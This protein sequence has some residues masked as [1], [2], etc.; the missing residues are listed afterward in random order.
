M[1]AAGLY[2]SSKALHVIDKSGRYFV[3]DEESAQKLTEAVADCARAAARASKP[4]DT[5]IL[6]SALET[7]EQLDLSM[8]PIGFRLPVDGNRDTA[9]TIRQVEK[10]YFISSPA[11]HDRVR[12]AAERMESLCARKAE[13]LAAAEEKLQQLFPA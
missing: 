3:V 5:P 4:S 9:D 6:E 13:V 11:T 7:I 2:E 12:Q 8:R 10:D 1:A